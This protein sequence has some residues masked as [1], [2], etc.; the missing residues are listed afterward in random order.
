MI[1][2][3]TTDGFNPQSSSGTLKDNE[4]KKTL[5]EINVRN[6]SVRSGTVEVEALRN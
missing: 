6:V 4:I 3:G 1:V 5:L 2:N